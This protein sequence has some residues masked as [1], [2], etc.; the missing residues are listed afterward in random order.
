MKGDNTMTSTSEVFRNVMRQHEQQQLRKHTIKRLFCVKNGKGKM[1]IPHGNL[2]TDAYDSSGFFKSKS[3]A[4]KF[5]DSLGSG[6]DAGFYVSRG[7]DHI[8]THGNK[9]CRYRLQPKLVA[10]YTGL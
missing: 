10:S 9:I 2:A 6:V 5:R 7:P 4:K 1:Q 8:G 3:E